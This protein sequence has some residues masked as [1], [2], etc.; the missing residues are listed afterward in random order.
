MTRFKLA[1]IAVACILFL[2]IDYAL[3]LAGN[4]QSVWVWRDVLGVISA[5]QAPIED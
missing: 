2:A 3:A 4:P 1:V 5:E